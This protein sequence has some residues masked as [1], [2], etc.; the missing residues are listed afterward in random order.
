MDDVNFYFYK[1]NSFFRRHM[2]LKNNLNSAFILVLFI[3]NQYSIEI[4]NIKL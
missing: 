3:I 4:F 2:I 1:M